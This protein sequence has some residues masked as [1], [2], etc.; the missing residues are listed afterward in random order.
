MIERIVRVAASFE[1]AAAFDREDLARLSMEERISEVDRLRRTWFGENPTQ[2]RLV[3][4]LIA[5]DPE[6]SSVRGRRRARGRRAR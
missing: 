2:S 3:R 4:V 1:E 6:R 5:L